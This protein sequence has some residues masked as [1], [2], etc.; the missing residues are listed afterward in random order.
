MARPGRKDRGLLSRPDSTG[1]PVWYVRLY[2]EGKDRRFGS[3]PNKT[4]AREFYEKAKLEQK[5]GRFFPERYQH[6]GYASLEELIANHVAVSTVKNQSAERH[7]GEWWTDRLKGKRLNAV[8]P[9]LLEEAQRDLLAEGLAPQTALHYMKFLRHILNKAIRDGKV[10]KNPFAR[11]KLPKAAAGK[12]RFLTAEEETAL[13]DR[14]GHPYG[15]W[16][17]L[18]MLTGLRLG[19]QFGLT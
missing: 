13:L 9:S 16:A 15:A 6:G 11:I 12:T 14:L 8:T 2:H 3:F 5:E 19:E 7:Y 17:R 18:A 4:K 1:K 10:E